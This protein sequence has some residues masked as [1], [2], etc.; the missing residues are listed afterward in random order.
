M[1]RVP[2]RKANDTPSRW[3]SSLPARVAGAVVAAPFDDRAED[4]DD[5]ERD[6]AAA[7]AFT[8]A[9][10]ESNIVHSPSPLPLLPAPLDVGGGDVLLL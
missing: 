8:A 1:E 3:L 5:G 2:L 9:A 7:A 4:D 6:E 10:A